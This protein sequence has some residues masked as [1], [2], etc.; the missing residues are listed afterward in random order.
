V[1]DR[2]AL[3][4]AEVAIGSY[5]T[6]DRSLDYKVKLTVE[7]A[8]ADTVARVVERLRRELPQGSL[9]REE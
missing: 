5:P 3:E 9:L 8:Q 2:V 4:N 1:L 6:F 7:H